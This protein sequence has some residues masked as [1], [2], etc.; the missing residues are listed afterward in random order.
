MTKLRM[1]VSAMVATG[2]AFVLSAGVALADRDGPMWHAHEDGWGWDGGWR[3]VMLVTMVL[4]WAAVVAVA[5]WVVRRL[6]RSRGV[7]KSPLDI[8]KERLA[9]GEITEEEFERLKQKL[10]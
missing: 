1:L 10:G 8:A 9:K 5:V 4:F 2:V 6:S 7:A 3:I